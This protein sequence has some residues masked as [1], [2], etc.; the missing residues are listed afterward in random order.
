MSLPCCHDPIEYEYET[1]SDFQIFFFNFKICML[2]LG[3]EACLLRL[4]SPNSNL[5]ECEM[6]RPERL[7]NKRPARDRQTLD[8]VC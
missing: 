7:D 3:L 1:D 4:L 8:I 6:Y 5:D 2:G